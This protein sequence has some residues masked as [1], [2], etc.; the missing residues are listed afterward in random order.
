[1]TAFGADQAAGHAACS[2]AAVAHTSAA[3]Q[4][5]SSLTSPHPPLH[6]RDVMQ[7]SQ[8]VSLA[9]A[10]LKKGHKPQQVAEK[11]AH[12]ACRRHTT[13]NVAVVIVDLGGGV[14]GWTRSSRKRGS[15][16][17]SS[18]QQGQ[19]S[20]SRTVGGDDKQTKKRGFLGIF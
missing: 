17:K 18:A 9:R 11:L 12:L 3:V 1:M 14:D 20:E 19:S 16:G 15:S 13:D 4:R 5:I 6:C 7:S 2:K 8:A 10:D